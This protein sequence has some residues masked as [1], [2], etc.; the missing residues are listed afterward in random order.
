M[1]RKPR[2]IV[3]CGC[4]CGQLI[5]NV[6]KYGR[7]RLYVNGHN[8]KKYEDPKQHKKEWRDRNRQAR[9]LAKVNYLHNRIS[10]MINIKGGKC[11]HCGK[12]YD[13][14][15]ASIFQ[16]HHENPETKK[17]ILGQG[18]AINYSW[19]KVE[20]ELDKCILL[21]TNCHFL[22]HRRL[23]LSYTMRLKSYFIT[24]KGNKCEK[25]GT[26]YDGENGVIFQFH[27]KNPEDKIMGI[28]KALRHWSKTRIQ[29]E[30]DKCDLLCGNCHAL[31]HGAEY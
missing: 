30:V 29:A 5:E 6:D 27:H 31:E 22:A 9:Y 17:F 24:S 10:K 16:F 13:G 15:N 2:V 18:N 1:Q 3:P 7:E 12:E 21:C 8:N 4:G 11:V 19:E 26:E 28:S 25:C 14:T 23:P 20:E